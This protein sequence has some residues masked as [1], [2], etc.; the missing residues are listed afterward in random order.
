MNKQNEDPLVKIGNIILIVVLTAA[1]LTFIALIVCLY[2]PKS[3]P[4]IVGT[5][6]MTTPSRHFPEIIEIKSN[7]D[8]LCIDDSDKT[9]CK[10]G[11]YFTISNPS[12][13]GTFNMIFNKKGSVYQLQM[14]GE[15][16]AYIILEPEGNTLFMKFTDKGEIRDKF[17]FKRI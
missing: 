5:W 1:A 6:R 14:I 15:D 9:S 11:V 3:I 13:S 12:G 4:S 16:N 7:T 17:H 2:Y 10:E 8:A